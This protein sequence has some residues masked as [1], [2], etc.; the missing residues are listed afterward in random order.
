ML[1]LHHFTHP[2]WVEEQ[3]G[4]LNPQTV[5]DFERYA[6]KIVERLGPAVR[7]WCTVNEP[8]VLSGLSYALGYFPP[9]H[10][11]LFEFMRARRQL[12]RAHERVYR[13]IHALY[14]QHGWA[15]PEVSFANHMVYVE[16]RNRF[17]PLDRLVAA[18]YEW[19]ANGYF[20][21]VM[22]RSSDFLGINYYFYHRL[23]F[24]LG[25]SMSWLVEE[26][27]LPDV[28]K[29]D[30]GWPVVAEGLYRICKSLAGW[31]KPIYITENG[32]ADAADGL[33]GWAIAEQVRVM[34]RLIAEGVPVRGYFYWSLLD[35]FEWE[36][37]YVPKYG[38]VE[39]NFATRARRVRDSARFYSE[40]ARANGMNN[41]QGA[42][43]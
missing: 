8:S 22:R 35:T 28:P 21:K 40:L 43:L 30:V 19:V 37:G 26:A 34:H 13:R 33:R 36:Q 38:L 24:K 27:S 11:R 5:E 6:V 7:L 42:T 15:R 14:E 18:G 12:A 4:W 2:V 39:V 16:P 10:K 23:Y 17:N 29:T 25:G 32:V 9:G 1:T 31:G 20:R 3:G 41:P